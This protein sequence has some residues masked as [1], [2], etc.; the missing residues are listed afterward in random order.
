MLYIMENYKVRY[1]RK[2]KPYKYVYLIM[3][4]SD[5]WILKVPANKNLNNLVHCMYFISFFY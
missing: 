3:L 5:L 4:K 2:T 1:C